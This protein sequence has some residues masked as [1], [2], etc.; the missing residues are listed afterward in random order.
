M[1]PRL[2]S[3]L[4]QVT[5]STFLRLTGASIVALFSGPLLLGLLG[6][7]VLWPFVLFTLFVPGMMLLGP[8][9]WLSA[10][11]SFVFFAAFPFNALF[12]FIYLPVLTVLL[13]ANYWAQQVG[14]VV[15]GAF[16]A[17]LIGYLAFG[18]IGNGLLSGLAGLVAAASFGRCVMGI[19]T[20]D[21]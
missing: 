19:W 4:S 18:S 2:K 20:S 21:E 14:L 10:T 6:F 1:E 16:G 7:V 13:P 8:A 11:I 3:R 5:P 15:L 17:F 9:L 12:V